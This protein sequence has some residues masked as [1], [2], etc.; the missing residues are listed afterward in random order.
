MA[1]TGGNTGGG[2]RADNTGGMVRVATAP[3]RTRYKDPSKDP[4]EGGTGSNDNGSASGDG[5]CGTSP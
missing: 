3:S 2:T 4:E 1:S 5:T